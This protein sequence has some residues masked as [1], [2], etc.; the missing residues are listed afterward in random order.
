MNLLVPKERMKITKTRREILPLLVTAP[1]FTDIFL[2]SASASPQTNATPAQAATDWSKALCDSTMQRIPDPTKLGGWGYAISLYLYGQFLVFKRTGEKKYLDYIQG[3]VDKHVS[4]DGVIDRSI[5]ALDYMLPGNLLLVLYTETIQEKYRKAAD[6][7][8]HRLDTYP[9]TED[10]G[11]W[12]ALS[13]QHQLW[14]D[15]MFMSMPFLVRY[16][17]AFHD[18]TCAN[19]EA[20]KQL[21]IYIKH[22]NDP[23]TGLMWHAYDESGAQPWAD[24]TTHHSSILWCRAIGWFGMALIDVLEILP[25][26]HPHRTELIAQVVQLTHA[27]AKYQ[28]AESGLW[29][30]VVD[31]GSIEGNWLE[32]SSS[33]MYTYTIYMAVQRKYI[34][35][36]MLEFACKG[37]RGVLT[38]LSVDA[39]GHAHIANIC[40]GTNLGD[41]NYYLNRPRNTDD[42][43]GLGAFL[44]MNE[45]L[46]HSHCASTLA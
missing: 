38:Q 7:I 6:S 36:K 21:L 12:H 16:G 1:F 15:G 34:P 41:L 40:G 37:Y 27:Y 28:D 39:D 25:H 5:S 32:T 46:R 26:N 20:A 23:A 4:D 10:A 30:Q 22:L 43:H 19:D 35:T 8:R 2:R 14:L 11:L 24:P 18:E 3:W 42:F 9:R 29:Y 44:I 33:S 13:R 31:K 45:Q 17:K